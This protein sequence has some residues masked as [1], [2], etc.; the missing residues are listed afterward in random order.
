MVEGD[1][2]RLQAPFLGLL[3]HM[4]QHKL[5]AL[6]NTVKHPYRSYKTFHLFIA[7]AY[8]SLFSDP[9][10]ECGVANTLTY[11]LSI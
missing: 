1:A 3:H 4:T 10:S 2:Q 8:F 5:V 7:A 11:Y 9:W 6:M